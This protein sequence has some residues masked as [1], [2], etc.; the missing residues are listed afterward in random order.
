[1]SENN[2]NPLSQLYNDIMSLVGLKHFT[3]T[4]CDTRYVQKSNTNG[5][6]KNEQSNY[7]GHRV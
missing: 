7:L 6:L 4:E 1:M 3:K 2:N 5:L